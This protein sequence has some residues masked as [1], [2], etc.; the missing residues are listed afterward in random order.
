MRKSRVAA[1]LFAG[2]AMASTAQPLCAQT[3]GEADASPAQTEVVEDEN[4]ENAIVVTGTRIRGARV[5][6]EVIALDREAIVEAGQIDLG[7]AIRTLPQNFAGGQNPGVGSGAGLG[8]DNVNSA[9]SPDLRGLGPDA[10][11][12]LINGH[13]VPYN[14]AYQGVDISAI[15]LAAVDRVEV[16]PDG[17]SALYG[18]DAVG[19]VINVV[20]RRDFEGLTTSGQLGASTDGGYFRQQFDLVGG[21][22]WDGGGVMLAYD[23]ANNSDITADQRSYTQSLDPQ[24]TLY[25]KIQRHAVTLAAHQEISPAVRIAVDGFYSRRNSSDTNGAPVFRISRDPRLEGYAISPSMEIDLAG[26]WQVKISGVYGRDQSRF[27]TT[28]VRQGAEPNLAQGR[29]FNEIAT[30]EAGAEGPLFELP[31]G[32]AR[33]A[34]GAGFRNNRLDY[35]RKDANY[36]SAFDITRRARF[37]YAE[38]YLP[39]VARRNARPGLDEFT[40]SAA[41]R[42]EDYPG[43]DQLATPRIGIIYSPVDGLTLSGSWSRS[44]KAPTLYQQY[45]FYETVLLPA[46]IVGAGN[47]S[48]TILL[49]AG[50]NP[51][52]GP[53]RAR[54]WTAG[55]EL[56]PPALPELTF[57]ASWYDIRY[58][59]RVTGPISGSI[60]AAFG[61]PGYASLIDFMPDPANLAALIGGAQFG[62]A[63]FTGAPYDPASVVA[64]ADNRNTNVAAWALKGIDARLSWDQALGQGRSLGLEI[65]GSWIDSEQRITAELPTTQLAGT[66]FNPAKLRMR[67]TARFVT[68]P[69]TANLAINYTGGLEDRRFDEIRR[70]A[71]T[72]TVDIGVSYTLVR[73]E[74]RDPGLE[75]SLTAQ[76][77]F[78][79]EPREIGQLGPYDTPYD[80]TNYSPIGRFIAFGIRRHW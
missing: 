54:S 48:D 75:I 44:F 14:S 40:I 16:L 23:F 47:G 65:A 39:F 17:A 9:S 41:V 67:S 50:G 24:V 12:T 63:N 62:L 6:G 73:G 37:G 27:R 78:N 46:S 19:G 10:T 22:I 49:V 21:T 7:E 64:V 31:G 45:I 57:S 69:L 53:E 1:A 42:Y 79:E 34:I 33:L 72:A 4:D 18:S 43:L 52:V 61:D 30:L 66:I 70:L 15:P 8:N 32:D 25:P 60:L 71:S 35:A 5:V 59:D 29:Y 58:T 13:R 36:D 80:S 3:T 55:L 38:L 26:D 76:N 28:I 74:G 20:L 68:G 51:D 77:L 56:R 11:L 2:T